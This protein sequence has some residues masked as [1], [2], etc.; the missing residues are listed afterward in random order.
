MIEPIEEISIPESSSFENEEN[1]I[2]ILPNDVKNYDAI[3][4]QYK[5]F[6]MYI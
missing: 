2:L 4:L 1:C 6:T 5:V 3:T